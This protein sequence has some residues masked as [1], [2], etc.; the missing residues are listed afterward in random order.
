MPPK[1]VLAHSIG[2][3]ADAPPPTL[4][5][6][7]T[8]DG[9]DAAWVRLTGELDMATAPRLDRL[10]RE[11]GLHAR[12][13]VLDLRDLG[14]VDSSGVHAI[15]DASI[16]SRRA[17]RRILLLRGRQGVDRV[18]TLTGTA[19]DVG[20]GDIHAVEPSVH[21]PRRSSRKRLRNE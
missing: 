12:V 2:R 16:R 13:I 7:W 6:S 9:R 17:G 19:Q 4:Q 10:L 11:P 15:V 3:R 8:N 21:A 5:C 20:N 14:F 18:F 1:L